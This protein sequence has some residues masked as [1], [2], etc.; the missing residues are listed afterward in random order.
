MVKNIIF[1]VNNKGGV[2]KTS[3][4]ADLCSALAQRYS[5]GI[6]DFDDQASLARTLQGT[7]NACRDIGEQDI[8]VADVE[9]APATTFGFSDALKRVQLDVAATHARMAVIPPGLTYEF[10]ERKADLEAVVREEMHDAAFIAV[11]LPPIPHPGMIFDYTIL[12]LM[13]G[14]GEEGVRLFPLIVATPDHNVIDIALRGFAKIAKYFESHGVRADNIHPLFVLNKVP[15]DEQ[16]NEVG[17]EDGVPKQR[18]TYAEFD[19]GFSAKL[20]E[21]GMLYVSPSWN[22][23][24]LNHVNRSFTY[25]GRRYRSVVFPLVDVIDGSFSLFHGKKLR[26]AEYPHLV[27]LVASH[28]FP[29]PN[30][31]GAQ[32]RVYRY[33]LQQMVNFIAAYAD[34]R[35]HKNYVRKKAVFDTTRVTNAVVDDLRTVLKQY[36]EHEGK[37]YF[38]P[39]TELVTA[40][41]GGSS[42]E[43][44]WNIPKS[45]SLRQLAK[46]L[47]KAQQECDPSRK[48]TVADIETMLD[49]KD[50]WGQTDEAWYVTDSQGEQIVG[51]SYYTYDPLKIQLAFRRKNMDPRDGEPVNPETYLPKVEMVLR[52]LARAMEPPLTI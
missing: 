34:V 51:V 23:S 17:D 52:N 20:G 13:K 22:R 16:K 11:D 12:P 30:E 28:N 46:V 14:A 35:P 31:D 8:V 10:P 3:V 48:G 40:P 25:N 4:L 26:L 32:E 41:N 7:D 2:G 29:I 49:R 5:V 43:V 24:Q 18:I 50:S 45:V 39:V 19:R 1:P 36:Y 6:V 44:W 21:M 37:E 15:I 27:D 9:L 33:G 38:Y 42:E 47:L